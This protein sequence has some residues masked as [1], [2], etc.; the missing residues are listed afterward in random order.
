MSEEQTVVA[1]S[2]ETHIDP[3][4]ERMINDTIT[5]ALHR[6]LKDIQPQPQ[7]KPVVPEASTLSNIADINQLKRELDALRAEREEEKRIMAEMSKQKQ[8]SEKLVLH[9]IV[10]PQV[11]KLVFKHLEENLVIENN[12]VFYKDED[13]EILPLEAGIQKFAESELGKALRPAKSVQ[14]QQPTTKKRVIVDAPPTGLSAYE[15]NKW[16][17]NQSTNK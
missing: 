6:K 15:R 4:I 8:V 5:K 14:F 2:E 7:A 3:K 13:G 9:D 16:Y 12:K 1:E 17:E 10:N 11:Q